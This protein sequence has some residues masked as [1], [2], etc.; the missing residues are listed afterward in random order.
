ML[1][2]LLLRWVS[3][4][5][6]CDKRIEKTNL[7]NNKKILGILKKKASEQHKCKTYRK[8]KKVSCK[9]TIK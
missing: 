2:K 1:S 8:M 6:G 4:L 5:C 3:M 7:V 9:R